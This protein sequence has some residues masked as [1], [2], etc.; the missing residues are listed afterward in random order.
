MSLNCTETSIHNPQSE[1]AHNPKRSHLTQP[2]TIFSSINSI[3]CTVQPSHNIFFFLLFS[4][5]RK[6]S[7]ICNFFNHIFFFLTVMTQVDHAF[8]CRRY[9]SL[10]LPRVFTL[11]DSLQSQLYVTL[12]TSKK[13]ETNLLFRH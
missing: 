11:L 12:C 6:P 13:I 10:S 8:V 4:I 2:Q 3:L 7:R 1:K 9:F 5:A